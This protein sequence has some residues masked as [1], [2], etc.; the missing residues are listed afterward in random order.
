MA[1]G[2]VLAV[3]LVRDDVANVRRFV[4]YTLANGVDHVVVVLDGEQPEVEAMLA[5]RPRTT[6][7]VLGSTFRDGGG[8]GGGWSLNGR[9]RIAANLVRVA[10]AEA[11]FVDWLFFV[12]GDE[13]PLVDRAAL[14]AVPDEVDVVRLTPFEA[15]TGTRVWFKRLLP[16]WRLER[17]RAA[18][19]ID[20]A[21]NRA[22]FR[23]HVAGKVG[24]RPGAPVGFGVHHATGVDQERVE[25][26]ADPG[27]RLLHHESPTYEEFVR[28]WKA[29]ASSGSHDPGMRGHRTRIY[30]AFSPDAPAEGREE[31]WAQL[32]AEYAT[33]DLA[34]LRA[35]RAVRRLDPRAGTHRP[36]LLT[37]SQRRRL[38][39]GLATAQR[40]PRGAVLPSRLAELPE[41]LQ[42]VRPRRRWWRPD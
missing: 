19:V 22:W 28:K 17:L 39:R 20:R 16:R 23:G 38:D 36:P 30:E 27:L 12:D 33:D 3:T 34:A 1:P 4:R 14:A 24:V 6:C 37:R 18:G 7:V 2:L 32:Y 35:L 10:C 8:Q 9:Q 21:D 5:E 41:A 29:L 31:R 26:Y 25:A 11:G 15:V 40:L 42:E 13:T